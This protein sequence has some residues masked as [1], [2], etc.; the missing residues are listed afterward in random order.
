M[1]LIHHGVTLTIEEHAAA[2]LAGS[3]MPFPVLLPPVPAPNDEFTALQS[4]RHKDQVTFVD[5]NNKKVAS[6]QQG[7]MT[8]RHQ[9]LSGLNQESKGALQSLHYQLIPSGHI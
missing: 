7:V 2:L 3:I 8:L 6:I 5:N 9:L 4:Q 1:G